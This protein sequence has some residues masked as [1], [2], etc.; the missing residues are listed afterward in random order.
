MILLPINFMVDSLDHTFTIFILLEIKQRDAHMRALQ[1]QINP[2]FLYNTLE[3]IHV[4][5]ESAT[6]R[7]S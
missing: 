6:R 5:L 2:H 7:T 4:C 3:Y 1:S